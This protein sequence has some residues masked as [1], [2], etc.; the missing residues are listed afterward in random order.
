MTDWSDQ[1]TVSFAGLC[2]AFSNNSFREACMKPNFEFTN[3]Q[4]GAHHQFLYILSFTEMLKVTQS[5]KN[6]LGG[7]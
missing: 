1:N 2:S 7:V 5:L 3:K 6:E 4:N